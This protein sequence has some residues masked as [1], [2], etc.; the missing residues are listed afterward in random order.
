MTIDAAR[1]YMVDDRIGAIAPGLDGDLVIHSGHPFDADSTVERVIVNG[2]E[3][4]R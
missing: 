4:L 1:M 3:V 2:K